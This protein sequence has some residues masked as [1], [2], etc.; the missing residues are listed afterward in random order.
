MAQAVA[1]TA[2]GDVYVAGRT[3]GTFAGQMS[4]GLP[5]VFVARYDVEGNQI[6]IRFELTSDAND[7]GLRFDTVAERLRL[8]RAN[9]ALDGLV[10]AAICLSTGAPD[11]GR[12]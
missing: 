12:G 6:S 3:F 4:P 11:R 10:D 7:P 5:D 8:G 2:A 9:L 1:I